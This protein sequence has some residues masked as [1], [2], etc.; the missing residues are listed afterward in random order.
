[1]EKLLIYYNNNQHL[2]C[3]QFHLGYFV[4]SRSWLSDRLMSLSQLTFRLWKL[5]VTLGLQ[6]LNILEYNIYRNMNDI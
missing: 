5:S 3:Q 1:M 4:E 6:L 2:F